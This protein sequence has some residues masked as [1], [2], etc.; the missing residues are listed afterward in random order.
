MIDH[1]GLTLGLLKH[2]C[3]QRVEFL[4]EHVNAHHFFGNGHRFGALFAPPELSLDS[5]LHDLLRD[6]GNHSCLGAGLAVIQEQHGS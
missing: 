4:D 3:E 6:A 5:E 1:G 2:P